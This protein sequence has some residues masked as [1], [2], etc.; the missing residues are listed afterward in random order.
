MA[1]QKQ[2]QAPERYHPAV[3]IPVPD[4]G[5]F[6]TVRKELDPFALGRKIIKDQPLIARFNPDGCLVVIAQDGK[7]YTIK[8]EDFPNE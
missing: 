4:G 8:P 2:I 3:N 1:K 6:P 7:K 5:G